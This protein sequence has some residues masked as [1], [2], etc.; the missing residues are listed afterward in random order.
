MAF[1]VSIFS[2]WKAGVGQAL[3]RRWS[4]EGGSKGL[5]QCALGAFYCCNMLVYSEIF[6]FLRRPR[7]AGPKT[8][9][10]LVVLTVFAWC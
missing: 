3:I 1:F 8:C 9:F 4:G 6:G 2:Y 10:L 5:G 7:V